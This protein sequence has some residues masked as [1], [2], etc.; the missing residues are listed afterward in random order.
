MAS[1]MD[2]PPIA[3]LDELPASSPPEQPDEL[4]DPEP[5]PEPPTPK[6]KPKPAQPT[7]AVPAAPP[8]KPKPKPRPKPIE[9]TAGQTLL[10]LPR[11]QKIMKADGDLL[12]VSKEA[13]HVISVATEEF[14]KRL[15]QSSH[16]LA[17]AQRR[18]TVDYKDAATAV[19]QGDQLQFLHETVPLAVPV[20]VAFQRR[21]A[22]AGD[23]PN[24]EG[25][26]ADS[27][28][29]AIKGKGKARVNL[30]VN[31][32]TNGKEPPP[33]PPMWMGMGTEADAAAMM[34][35]YPPPPHMYPPN[36][37]FPGWGPPPGFPMPPGQPYMRG[38]PMHPPE[39][40]P[41]PHMPP[42][43]HMPP[44][45]RPPMPTHRGHP[46]P[47]N[48]PAAASGTSTSAS[49][50]GSGATGS[51]RSSR[52]ISAS[53]TA[54][55]NG[56]G[57]TNGHA[58]TNGDAGG[59]NDSSPSSNGASPEFQSAPGRTIYNPSTLDPRLLQS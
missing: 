42:P 23:I 21:E 48:A 51:R 44:H 15:A 16:K 54:Q 18:T 24:G 33:P 2:L 30:I 9:R 55:T 13:M 57:T 11:V 32:K 26:H 59:G 58:H 37:Y 36:G 17:A 50:S 52:R 56:N 8:P 46:P 1:P 47:R 14:L 39:W 12:P 27:E 35:M 7:A 40:A 34:H 49:G 3:T 41:Y 29:R 25:S 19:Q 53:E 20:S 38:P 10:P 31:G 45:M 5:E 6:A 43:P 28:R 22:K 4:A